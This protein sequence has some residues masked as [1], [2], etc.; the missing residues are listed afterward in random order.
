MGLF[1]RT[2]RT[3]RRALPNNGRCRTFARR[4]THPPAGARP[5]WTGRSAQESGVPAPAWQ[6]RPQQAKGVGEGAGGRWARR[7]RHSACVRPPTA[8]APCGPR[9]T[10]IRP[11]PV[12]NPGH[13]EEGE[14]WEHCSVSRPFSGGRTRV[15]TADMVPAL[16]PGRVDTRKSDNWKPSGLSSDDVCDDAPAWATVPLCL[17][18]ECSLMPGYGVAGDGCVWAWIGVGLK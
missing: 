5:Q 18:L 12:A 1:P 7:H 16:P 14:G 2:A 8:A 13:S 6:Q 3:A 4:P 9:I 11:R 10:E 15:C 17:A